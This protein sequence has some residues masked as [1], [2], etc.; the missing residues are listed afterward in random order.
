[1]AYLQQRQTVRPIVIAVTTL[2]LGFLLCVSFG[3]EQR[4]V[5]NRGIGADETYP[6]VQERTDTNESFGDFLFGDE[7]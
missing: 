1:M 2:G 4:V 3:C 7:N 6:T 5:G